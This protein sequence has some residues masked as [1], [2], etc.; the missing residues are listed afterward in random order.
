MIPLV[1]GI[2][3]ALGAVALVLDPVLRPGRARP[4]AAPEAE[5]DPKEHRKDL[6]LAAL[7]EIEFDR[8]TGKLD[9][10]DYERMK[11]T[12][13]TEALEAIRAADAGAAPVPREPAL[14]KRQVPA[15][16]AAGAGAVDAAADDDP[17]E[18]L[19]AAKR[20]AAKS[21]R[22][23]CAECGAELEGAGKFCVECGART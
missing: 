10:A 1:L 5:D 22:R 14:A 7:K 23:F 20:Q 13:T 18:A 8:A 3:V 19:I 2:V 21:G 12:Y 16:V 9:D 17:A 11:A 6:A 15:G 4:D